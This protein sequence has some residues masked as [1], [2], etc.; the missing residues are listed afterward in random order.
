MY[1]LQDGT[2]VQRDWYSS[3]LLYCCNITNSKID[4]EKCKENFN[5]MYDKEKQMIEDIK[6]R[7][8]HILNSGIKIPR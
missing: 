2:R 8:L 4:K 5:K 3:Y 1:N 7:K 6:A